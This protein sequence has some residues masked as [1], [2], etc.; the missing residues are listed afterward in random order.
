MFLGDQQGHKLRL[1][2][3]FEVKITQVKV[4]TDQCWPGKLNP[5]RLITV[6]LGWFCKI[7]GDRAWFRAA[8]ATE[9]QGLVALQ[10]GDSK[11]PE[12]VAAQSTLQG[13]TAQLKDG[14]V[15]RDRRHQL[16]KVSAALKPFVED[17]HIPSTVS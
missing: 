17:L 2:R 14:H 12:T 11:S 10:Q 1:C 15:R 4:V 3:D 6:R 16:S 13:A 7:N 5:L 9:K 8:C